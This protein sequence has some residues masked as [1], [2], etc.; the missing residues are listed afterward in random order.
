MA[1]AVSWLLAHRL[2][3]S[4]PFPS[5]VVPG[6]PPRAATP[7]WCYGNPAVAAALLVAA[8]ASSEPD[9]E[10]EALA[11]A[12]EAAVRPLEGA[13]T[14]DAGLCHGAAGIAHI[15]NRLHQAT[16]DVRFREA[17]LA[18]Y[19]R[20]LELR[21]ERGVGGYLYWHG[22]RGTSH[23]QALPG[24]LMGAAGTALALLA[25]V[26]DVEPQWDRALLVSPLTSP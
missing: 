6:E 16:G 2:G 14:E 5:L 15:Y 3:G 7:A 26:D 10:R 24:L 12:V 20:V 18:W 13:A 8:R 23:L 25:A 1:K 11:L 19:L 4:F 22:P 17:A 21:G 9:L